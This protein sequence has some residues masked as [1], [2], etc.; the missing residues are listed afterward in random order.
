VKSWIL[1]SISSSDRSA[2]SMSLQ[3]TKSLRAMINCYTCTGENDLFNWIT[4]G[5]STGNYYNTGEDIFSHG[6]VKRQCF[7]VSVK[8]TAN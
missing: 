3:G 5:N 6:I 4:T 7:I 2:A 1:A 8:E